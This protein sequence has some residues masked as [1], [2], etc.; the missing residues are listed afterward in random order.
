MVE[1]FGQATS[2]FAPEIVSK[3]LFWYMHDFYCLSSLYYV[4]KIYG[5]NTRSNQT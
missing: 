3:F 1:M 2:K 4:V 5:G